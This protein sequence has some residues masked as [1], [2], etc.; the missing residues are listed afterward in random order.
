MP[1]YTDNYGLIKPY[2]TENYDVEVQNSNMDKIDAKIKAVEDGLVDLGN[3]L[4]SHKAEY[5]SNRQQ[6][7]LK[8]AKV[9]KEL[10]DYK[11]TMQQVN[12]NQEPKQKA[13][14][15]GVISLPPNAAEGQVSGVKL[16]GQTATNMIKN[17]DF[18]DGAEKWV[19]HYS[20]YS[21]SNEIFN[22]I[23]DGNAPGVTMYQTTGIKCVENKQVF[24]RAIV[25]P[26]NEDIIEVRLQI[27]GSDNGN[28]NADVLNSYTVNQLYTLRGIVTIN[29][30]LAGNIRPAI[31]CVYPDAE[32]AN[33]KEIE[34][35]EVFALDLT[36]LGLEDKTADEINEMFPHYFEDTKSTIGAV[37]I[38]SVG[39]NLANL[40]EM[41]KSENVD[42]VYENGKTYLTWRNDSSIQQHSILKGKF[43][44]NTQYTFKGY[45]HN[46]ERNNSLRGGLRVK[47]T[48]GT[49][50]VIKTADH[51]LATDFN[52]VSDP[53]KTIDCLTGTWQYGALTYLHMDT[54]Q[55][56][57]GDTATSYEPYRESNAY[58]IA[59][60][61]EGNILELR[62]LPNGTKDEI[63]ITQGKLIK[64]ISDEYTIKA[65]DIG[66]LNRDL[67][68]VD[69]VSVIL[70]PDFVKSHGMGKF[71]SEL[72]EVD[73]NDRDNITSIGAL[74]N[75]GD[76]TLRYIIEKG[77]TLEQAKQQLVGITL[78]YQLAEPVEIPIQVSGTLTSYPNGTIYIER[79]LPDAGVYTDKI[80]ILH[81]DA[82]IKR[83]DKLSKVDF[84]TGIETELDI[85]QAEISEDK[86]SFTHPELNAGDI[87]FFEYEYDVESTE[88]ETEVEF[89]DS[90]YVVK[91]DVTGK[92]YKWNV[93]VSNGTP[94][95]EVVE[96]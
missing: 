94:T 29:S 96:V 7:Q 70:P 25:K 68:N 52:F 55:I 73:R 51:N 16:K 84:M 75:F 54:L 62:S 3:E 53:N 22:L 69:Q 30:N 10:N 77:T 37:R 48:D 92:F 18:K 15:Y 44:P 47:Y 95:I 78:I 45:F 74:S 28:L 60:D 63:D 82:P 50:Q 66:S 34:V 46:V 5:T 8:I 26:K 14:G 42:V 65:T 61:E 12:I 81:Q 91:D 41:S 43:L 89:Y 57:K 38:K 17:G 40:K 24:I 4:E 93:K 21:F 9:E 31:V 87:V 56:E 6:D 23:G 90:R 58:V 33:G 39:K 83:L 76:G 1:Q 67:T 71:K 20:T 27:R 72:R 35:H 85:S 86:L 11:A 88:G 36:A 13:T 49:S 2:E 19:F 64:R 80:T 79:I 32:T 59:K